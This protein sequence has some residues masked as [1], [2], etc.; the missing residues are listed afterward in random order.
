MGA[1]LSLG[2][3]PESRLPGMRLMTLRNGSGC[4]Y[5]KAY[6]IFGLVTEFAKMEAN[7]FQ[8]GC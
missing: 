6:L 8:V 2:Y 7:K 1:V 5:S 3:V 4:A